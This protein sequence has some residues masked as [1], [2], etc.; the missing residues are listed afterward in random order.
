[1]P[2]YLSDHIPQTNYQY[3]NCAAE[4]VTTFYRR[5]DAFEYSFSHYTVLEW[6]RLDWNI[7]NSKTML[8]FKNSLLKSG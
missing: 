7:Q 1:M 2:Q 4:D 3:N 6:N 5:T 8:S